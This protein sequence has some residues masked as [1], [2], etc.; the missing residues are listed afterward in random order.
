MQ[1]NISFYSGEGNHAC[2]S[3]L[4]SCL[5]TRGIANV[6]S[7]MDSEDLPVMGAHGYCTQVRIFM[8]MK[9]STML[10]ST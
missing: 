9:T 4:Y 10:P 1:N 8:V 5:L 3:F 6:S 2:I 7:D